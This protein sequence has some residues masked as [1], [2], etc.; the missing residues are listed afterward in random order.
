MA[1]AAAEA[2]PDAAAYP[3]PFF[4]PLVID[5]QF[6]LSG[7]AGMLAFRN[8]RFNAENDAQEKAVRAALRAYGPD[9]AD[10]WQGD[11]R[12]TEWTCKKCGFRTTNDN[13]QEDHERSPRHN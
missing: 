5:E 2:K 6:V 4:N 7:E 13:A 1:N 11:T 10:R 3:K 8:G 12:R 9:K